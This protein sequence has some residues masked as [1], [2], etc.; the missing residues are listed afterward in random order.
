[1]QITMEMM[2]A[3]ACGRCYS[4]PTGITPGTIW[5][6]DQQLHIILVVPAV[7]VKDVSPFDPLLVLGDSAPEQPIKFPWEKEKICKVLLSR[8]ATTEELDSWLKKEHGGAPLPAQLK[9]W[10]LETLYA[11]YEAWDDHTWEKWGEEHEWQRWKRNKLDR[12]TGGTK[13]DKTKYTQ[14]YIRQE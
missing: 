3:F 9:L 14:Y 13:S 4:Q 1:M 10:C 8:V 12:D 6:K 5:L 7:E 2:Y 11:P